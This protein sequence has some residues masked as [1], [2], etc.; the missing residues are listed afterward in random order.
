MAVD[1]S[2]AADLVGRGHGTAGTVDPE[3]QRPDRGILAR[4]IERL[5][6]ASHHVGGLASEER[7]DR[8]NAVDD[9]VDLEQQDLRPPLA[10]QHRLFEGRRGTAIEEMDRDAS[11]RRHDQGQP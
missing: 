6:H 4:P 8:G 7:V 10:L 2:W 11:G 3:Q 5:G 9:P 1:C